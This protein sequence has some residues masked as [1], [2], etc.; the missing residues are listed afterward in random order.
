MCLSEPRAVHVW[1][2][3][4]DVLFCKL[5]SPPCPAPLAVPSKSNSSTFFYRNELSLSKISKQQADNNVG[6]FFVHFRATRAQQQ[7]TI[8]LVLKAVATCLAT[9]FFQIFAVQLHGKVWC[10][11]LEQITSFT[12][13][14]AS[15]SST[16]WLYSLVTALNVC[17]QVFW[18]SLGDTT[19]HLTV[20][21]HHRCSKRGP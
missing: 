17:Q 7:L 13:D 20:Q 15:M 6:S 16:A 2:Y 4:E 1:R 18:V 10:G 14:S 12:S 9:F 19:H 3:G 21:R 5:P 8:A 11:I